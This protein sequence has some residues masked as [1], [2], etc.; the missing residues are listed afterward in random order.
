MASFVLAIAMSCL[1]SHSAHHWDELSVLRERRYFVLSAGSSIRLGI[2]TRRTN[3]PYSTKLVMDS[4]S[5]TWV[6]FPAQGVYVADKS[7]A[8]FG[9]AEIGRSGVSRGH[10]EDFTQRIIFFPHWFAVG[11]LMLLPAMRAVSRI[12]HRSVLYPAAPF[13]CMPREQSVPISLEATPPEV[14][15]QLAIQAPPV[16]EEAPALPGAVE[17]KPEVRIVRPAQPLEDQDHTFIEILSGESD[18]SW[19]QAVLEIMG[20]LNAHGVPPTWREF[21]AGPALERWGKHFVSLRCSA[22]SVTPL[23]YNYADRKSIGRGL[24]VLVRQRGN[25]RMAHAWVDG[26][27]SVFAASEL[28]SP[29]LSAAPAP[30]QLAG[31][32]E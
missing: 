22:G 23:L 5:P 11:V 30:P 26:V 1:W 28:M 8:S 12:A 7:G 4:F 27:K 15:L 21:S 6:F 14:A 16:V 9:S 29:P 10:I 20:M 18:D 2:E 25:G 19:R 31:V 32:S 24:I 13:D 17:A 3:L